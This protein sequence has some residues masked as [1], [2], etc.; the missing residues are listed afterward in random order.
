[1]Y[2]IQQ[3]FGTISNT[4]FVK[5]FTKKHVRL[6]QNLANLFRILHSFIRFYL[7]TVCLPS[8]VNSL[9]HRL[10][11]SHLCPVSFSPLGSKCTLAFFFFLSASRPT[12]SHF[13]K[14]TLP[15]PPWIPGLGFSKVQPIH[16]QHLRISS[17]TGSWFG[18]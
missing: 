1:M 12:R 7:L 10:M 18:R 11:T 15:L 5:C 8:C 17:Y 2:W 3:I 9:E 4:H 16:Y 6:S 13:L 14:C